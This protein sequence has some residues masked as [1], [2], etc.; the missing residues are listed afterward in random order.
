[1]DGR[2]RTLAR[3]QLILDVS[4]R[5]VQDYIIESVS[6]VLRSAPITYVKWDMNRNM[7][8][9][10]SCVLPAHQKMETQHRYMLG[11]YR[12]LE[13]ITSAFPQVLFESCSGGGGRFDCGI[14]HYMPRPGPATIPTPPSV[15]ASSTA[16]P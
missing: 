1:V 2:D 15:C 12:V 9:G 4:R 8:E 11:L 6:A 7:T 5:E 3:R 16:R 14:L 10:F 13:E